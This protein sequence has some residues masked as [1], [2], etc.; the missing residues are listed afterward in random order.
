MFRLMPLVELIW[1]VLLTYFKTSLH[2]FIY[3]FIYLFI[4]RALPT[5]YGTSQARDQ[6]GAVAAGLHHSHSNSSSEPCL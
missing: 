2:L 4:F 6:I 1:L 5:A 3:L